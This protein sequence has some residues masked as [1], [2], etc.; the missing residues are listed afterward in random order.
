MPEEHHGYRTLATLATARAL[1]PN[2]HGLIW[3]RP[4]GS[5]VYVTSVWH[6]ADTAFPGYVGPVA[7][8]LRDAT[9]EEADAAFGILPEAAE[10]AATLSVGSD[11]YPCTILARSRSGHCLTLR[12]DQVRRTD[13][14]GYGEEQSYEFV[15]NPQAE[16]IK[17]YRRQNGRYYHGTSPVT[18][19]RRAAYRDP[20][21]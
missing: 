17:A 20:S 2:N 19:G 15:A 1:N 13:A 12:Y 9:K 10:D 21:Y 4:D 7:H 8:Y 18:L 16:T 11:S 6:K 5:E 14:N 3:A